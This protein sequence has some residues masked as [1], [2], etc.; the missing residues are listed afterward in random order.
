MGELLFGVLILG[1][2][3]A[4]V[5][6]IVRA[7]VPPLWLLVKPWSCDLCMSWWSSLVIS[8]IVNSRLAPGLPMSLVVVLAAAAVSMLVLKINSKLSDIGIDAPKW[9]DQ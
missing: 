9:E 5:A 4:T 7:F 2:A 1:L 3:A 6:T 8:P